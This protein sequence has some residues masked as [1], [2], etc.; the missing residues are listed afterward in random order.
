MTKH[1]TLMTVLGAHGFSPKR[2]ALAR[3]GAVLAPMLAQKC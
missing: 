3:F 2:F 1:Y